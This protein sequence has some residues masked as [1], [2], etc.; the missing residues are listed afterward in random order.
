M[1]RTNP[2]PLRAKSQKQGILEWMQQGKTITPSIALAQFGCFK[3]ATRVSELIWD[4]GHTEICK[5]PIEVRTHRGTTTV[6]SYFIDPD[7]FK[8]LN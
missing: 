6:M 4:D 5:K 8:E 1:D 7:Y 2:N 3:L